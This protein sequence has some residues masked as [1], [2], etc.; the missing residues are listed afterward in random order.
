MIQLL[1]I[2]S[3][4]MIENSQNLWQY[5]SLYSVDPI[6]TGCIKVKWSKVNGF[7]G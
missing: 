6:P 1:H 7:E 4:L 5:M 2:E 3:T